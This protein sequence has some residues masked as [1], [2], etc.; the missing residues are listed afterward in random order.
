MRE[1]RHTRVVR[2]I[3]NIL[4]ATLVLA[5]PMPSLAAYLAGVVPTGGTTQQTFQTLAARTINV[6]DFGAKCDAANGSGT[7]DSMDL[8]KLKN[9]TVTFTMLDRYKPIVISGAGNWTLNG[10]VT[11]G[12]PWIYNI[13]YYTKTAAVPPTPVYNP[14]LMG[15]AGGASINDN[16]GSGYVQTGS[17]VQTGYYLNPETGTTSTTGTTNSS[18]TVYVGATTLQLIG[19]NG[20]PVFDTSNSPVT[21]AIQ[22]NMYVL[23]SSG[24]IPAG[25]YV[26]NV[27]TVNSKITISAPA[28]GNNTNE[29]IYI[30]GNIA[31]MTLTAT[32]TSSAPP[33]YDTLTISGG[34]LTT[35]INNLN[36]DGSVELAAAASSTVAQ[37]VATRVLSV[38]YGGSGYAAGDFIQ[39]NDLGSGSPGT[40][41]QVLATTTS[42][43]THGIITGANVYSQYL[44]M[45]HVTG[46]PVGQYISSGGGLAATFN[47]DYSKT[48]QFWYGTDDTTPINAALMTTPHGSDVWLPANAACG[49]TGSINLPSG[50]TSLRGWDW[51]GSGIVALGPIGLDTQGYSYVVGLPV[52]YPEGGGM[53][54]LF[55]EANKLAQFSCGVEGGEDQFYGNVQCEDATTSEW[56][57]G[58]PGG[59]TN[60][61]SG[62]VFHHIRGVTPFTKFGSPAFLPSENFLA[63]SGC[64]AEQ[65]D[66][67]YFRSGIINILDSQSHFNLYN[68]NVEDSIEPFNSQYCVEL[69]GHQLLSDNRCDDASVAGIYVNSGNAIVQGAIDTWNNAWPWTPPKGVTYGVLLAPNVAGDLIDGVLAG[70][71]ASSADIIFQQG[72]ANSS[73]IAVNN[74]GASYSAFPT[75]NATP[76]GRLTLTNGVPVMPG[77][78]STP[79][80]TL[81]YAPFTGNLVPI[82]VSG[83]L[84]YVSFTQ[85]NAGGLAHAL[86]SNS[87]DTNYVAAGK[88]YDEFIGLNAGS[89][90]LCNGPSWSSGSSRATG[91][92]LELFNGVLANAA[93]IACNNGGS[94]PTFTC[95]QDNCS[96]LGSFYATGNGQ[97]T[98]NPQPVVASGGAQAIVGIWNAYN[99]APIV[100][101]EQDNATTYGVHTASTWEFADLSHSGINSI[102]AL[103]GNQQTPYDLTLVQVVNNPAT[104]VNPQLSI[105]LTGSVSPCTV[106]ASPATFSSQQSTNA[107]SVTYKLSNSPFL[108]LRCAQA[109]EKAGT[110]A[111]AFNNS[112]ALTLSLNWQY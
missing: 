101:A 57:C 43:S 69:T 35:M 32:G 8:M 17:K 2:R 27:D 61:I 80:T 9:P 95:P 54:D 29:T 42:G 82:N 4:F 68:G 74:P 59:N 104:G 64:S 52:V 37:Y 106:A 84:Q 55:V 38:A 66:H 102:L 78:S 76:Q 111:S 105:S 97:I 81:Y 99:R 65:V 94:T 7:I 88:I 41:V 83:N 71:V 12:F 45:N 58:Y 77:G 90:T 46:V 24:D 56:L 91:G 20:Q 18:T 26:T 47:L 96:Y 16:T 3:R 62:T 10:S 28:T 60:Q 92:S 89:P 72:T 50:N 31:V 44:M 15:M 63:S 100:A 79:Y 33:A 85:S 23:S 30:G 87:G 112:S 19:Q 48:G 103:D 39:L 34:P 110:T 6:T 22:D 14:S 21:I 108:G 53:R 5:L 25:T 1:V 11:S 36:G 49:V 86:D 51:S 40:T 93:S 98:F 67:S 107:I 75:P 73:T 109:Q 13:G 70:G